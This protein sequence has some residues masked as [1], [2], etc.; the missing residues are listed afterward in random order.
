M[1]DDKGFVDITPQA[2]NGDQYRDPTH[3][4][5]ENEFTNDIKNGVVDK[6]SQTLAKWLIEKQWGVDVRKALAI[7][8]VWLSTKW[9]SNKELIDKNSDRQ[10][11]V[12]KRQTDLEGKFTNVISSATSDSEV[13]DARNSVKFGKFGT[14]DARFEN[15]EALITKYVPQGF[16]VTI[17]HNLNRMP[18]ISVFTY[19]WAIGTETNGLDT[20]PSGLF[21]GSQPV[22]VSNQVVY[23]DVNNVKVILPA[24]YT[25]GGTLEQ[26]NGVW[27]LIDGIK[28]L[29]FVLS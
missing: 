15:M 13:I 18:Q 27:Y 2:G 21:G 11:Q 24:D 23:S 28:T 22:S 1:A 17:N 8:V 14:I 19:D 20:A 25:Q 10:S 3:I 4:P 12:E 9:H 7:F 26:H 29:K 16:E 6:N 5:S